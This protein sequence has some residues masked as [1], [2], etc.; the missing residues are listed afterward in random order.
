[1]NYSV[2]IPT[3][4]RP[5]NLALILKRLAES[6]S[7]RTHVMILTEPGSDSLPTK[8]MMAVWSEKL[9]I[10]I[11]INNCNVGVDESILRAYEACNSDWIYFLGDSK[12]PVEDFERVITFANMDC[13]LAA[14]YFFF[15]DSSF[16]GGIVIR[17]IEDLVRSGLTL[18]DFIL[19]GNSIFSRQIVEKYIRYS[20]RTLSCRIA[21]VA[22]PLIAITKGEHL[23]ISS[24]SII[25][26][27]IEKPA[28]YNPGKALL[29]CWTSFSLL[30][31][32]P[33]SYT[34]ARLINK[35]VIKNENLNSRIIFF[36]YCCIKIFRE[37]IPI[38][39]DLKIL[40]KTRF[41]FYRCMSEEIMLKLLFLL[42]T[43]K[44]IIKRK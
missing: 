6:V 38:A 27:F 35:Y 32:L 25:E 39:K 31:L 2:V 3:F 16:N 23:F 18:G 33:V 29:D 15:Y 36:K 30:T 14:A 21:H 17:T 9:D 10:E 40:Q 42:L 41:I 19:G 13:P 20:Y 11:L 12:L 8:E 34:D 5:E 26:K 24:N 37:N 7:K 4:E 1:M 44:S 28:S 22:M 43:V